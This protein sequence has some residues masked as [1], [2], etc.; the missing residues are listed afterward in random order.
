MALINIDDQRHYDLMTGL[1]RLIPF[2]LFFFS[3]DSDRKKM[4]AI[5]LSFSKQ[6]RIQFSCL[7]LRMRAKQKHSWQIARK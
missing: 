5:Q 6:P 1:Y 2:L 4:K 3:F 7:K